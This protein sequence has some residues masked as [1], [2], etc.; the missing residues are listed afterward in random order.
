MGGGER[1]K[2]GHEDECVVDP[3]GPRDLEV[4]ETEAQIKAV[5]PKI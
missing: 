5:N 4:Q 3:E 2:E 1:H